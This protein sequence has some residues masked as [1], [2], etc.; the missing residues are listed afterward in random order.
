MAEANNTTKPDVPVVFIHGLYG[1][2]L[3]NPNT[4][5]RHWLTVKIALGLTKPPLGLPFEFDENGKQKTDDLK[6]TGTMD[7]IH[8]LGIKKSVYGKFMTGMA[9]FNRPFSVFFYDWRRSLFE[10]VD[11]FEKYLDELKNKH[12][13]SKIQ[14]VAHSMGGYITL[15]LLNRRPDLFHS[16]IFAGTPFRSIEYLE[17]LHLGSPIIL[18]T[19]IK[20]PRVMASF[21]SIYSFFSLDGQGLF[22][23]KHNPIQVDWFNVEDWKKNKFGVYNLEPAPDAQFDKFLATTLAKA[24]EFKSLVTAR[25]DITY[26]PIACITC[27]IHPTKGDILRN[28]PYAKHGYDFQ[29]VRVEGDGTVAYPY[30]IPPEGIP[31]KE[32]P[33]HFQHSDM[34]NDPALVKDI[35]SEL[36]KQAATK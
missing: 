24:K 35:L 21:G 12:G 9:D 32:Y 5:V 30:M 23:E 26:P 20:A 29:S 6:A 19:K 25:K 15:V 3:D 17:Y 4:G 11:L 13:Q 1:S 28:G 22:D 34:L 33:T 31:F 36:L 2:Y 16:V 14:V 10:S 8:L 27:K 18:N 7:F